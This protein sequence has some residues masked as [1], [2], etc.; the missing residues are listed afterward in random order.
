MPG[1][2]LR[3]HEPNATGNLFYTVEPRMGLKRFIFFDKNKK[4]TAPQNKVN[5]G[6]FKYTGD[7]TVGELAKQLN[8]NSSDIIKYLFN[9]IL[10]C[11]NNHHV[12]CNNRIFLLLESEM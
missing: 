2:K 4:N 12:F 1:E 3:F 9:L 7:V 11:K 10:K 5:G 6:V 8:L